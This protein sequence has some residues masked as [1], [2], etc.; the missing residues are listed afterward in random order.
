MDYD[1]AAFAQARKNRSA[2]YRVLHVVNVTGI[3]KG[4]CRRD[5]RGRA[6]PNS[7]TTSRLK[8]IR[9]CLHFGCPSGGQGERG[10]APCAPVCATSTFGGISSY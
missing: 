10:D 1:T 8:V 3:G 2:F 6:M 4:G 9:G 5:L 7:L